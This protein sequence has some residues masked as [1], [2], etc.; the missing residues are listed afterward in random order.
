MLRRLSPLEECDLDE[1]FEREFEEGVH[2]EHDLELDEASSDSFLGDL[3]NAEE[4]TR[5]TDLP[6]R[7]RP[8]RR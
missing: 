5:L 1:V 3:L 7:Q 4:D 8:R 6:S 2:I